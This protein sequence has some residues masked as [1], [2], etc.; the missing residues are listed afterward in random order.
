MTWIPPKEYYAQIP[1]RPIGVGIVYFNHANEILLVKPTYTEHWGFLGGV[2]EADEFPLAGLKREIEE[3]IGVLPPNSF[4][5]RCVDATHNGY[6]QSIQLLFDGGTIDNEVVQQM[7]LQT[8]E[9]EGVAF[10][11]LSDAYSRLGPRRSRL[12]LFIRAKE[13]NTCLY[14]ES[15]TASNS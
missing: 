15:E 12:E 13:E 11:N 10:F 8:E 6:S 9:L 3:E 7:I 14:T 4:T 5:L 2:I 1:K